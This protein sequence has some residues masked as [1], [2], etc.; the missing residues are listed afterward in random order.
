[1]D[2]P[3][4]NLDARLRVAIREEIRLMRREPGITTVHVTHD[5]D[6][7]MPISDRK[8]VMH[9]SVIRQIAAPEVV[10]DKPANAF[11]AGF[12]GGCNW[13]ACDAA[14]DPPALHIAGEVALPL[15]A[16]VSVRGPL[17]AGLRAGDVARLADGAPGIV[18]RML[19]RSFLGP[20]TR[21]GVETAGGL[22]LDADP[23]SGPDCPRDGQAVRPAPMPGRARLYAR[24]DGRRPA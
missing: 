15:A 17:R 13:S 4:S 1:M 18:A 3:L 12:I 19:V 9:R 23:P 16:G 5:H 24:D 6:E 10:F 21:L 2:E 11:V 7:A 14:G 22:P 8:A 20:R